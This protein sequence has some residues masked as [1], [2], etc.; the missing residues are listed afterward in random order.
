MKINQKQLTM[1]LFGLDQI[2]GEGEL[3]KMTVKEL[4]HKIVRNKL[5]YVEIINTN[6]KGFVT[7]L[8]LEEEYEDNNTH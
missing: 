8:A 4:A 5:D 1:L 7:K 6:D 3:G 2:F